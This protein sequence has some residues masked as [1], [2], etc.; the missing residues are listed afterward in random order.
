MK[1]GD[2]VRVK[3]TEIGVPDGTLAMIVKQLERDSN[4][5]SIVVPVFEVQFLSN[6]VATS[7]PPLTLYWREDLE[8]ISASR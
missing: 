1:V 7:P 8:V 2:L 5:A 3:H 4:G 6:K